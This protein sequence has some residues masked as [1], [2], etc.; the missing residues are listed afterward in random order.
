MV[1]SFKSWNMNKNTLIPTM[2][3]DPSNK[4]DKY[5]YFRRYVYYLHSSLERIYWTRSPQGL[6]VEGV[7]TYQEY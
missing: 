3:L 1:D 7:D 6:L 2:P 5:L 4:L